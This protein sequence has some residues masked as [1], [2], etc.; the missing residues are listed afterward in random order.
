[1]RARTWAFPIFMF[2]QWPEDKA[3]WATTMQDIQAKYMQRTGA[4]SCRV[5]LPRR[6]VSRVGYV[7]TDAGINW[8]SRATAVCRTEILCEDTAGEVPNEP[9]GAGVG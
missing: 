5:V 1:M 9:D 3:W 8:T 4:R 7:L 2:G 6:W